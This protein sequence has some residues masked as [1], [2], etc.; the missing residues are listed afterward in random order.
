MSLGYFHNEKEAAMA[1][2]V[3][4]KQFFGEYAKF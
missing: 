1:Y 4:A 2:A 3:K